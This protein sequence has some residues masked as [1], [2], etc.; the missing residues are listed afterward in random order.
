MR[1]TFR[2]GVAVLGLSLFISCNPGD[3]QETAQADGTGME[4]IAKDSTEA[5]AAASLVNPVPSFFS[6]TLPCKDCPGIVHALSLETDSTCILTEQY[7]GRKEAPQLRFGRVQR[8]DS[9][10][11]LYFPGGKTT[12]FRVSGTGMHMVDERGM[13]PQP[14]GDYTLR[15]DPAGFIDLGQPYLV[16]GAYFFRSEGA[17]FTPAG[18]ATAYPV[19]PGKGSFDAEK[20]YLNRSR[21]DTGTLC[22]RAIVRIMKAK[23]LAGKELTMAHIDKVVGRKGTCK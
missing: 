2:F 20:I 19:N 11:T 16:D 22:L 18:H 23:D 5:F 9:T 1:Y 8:T 13:S 12:R 7:L 17:T 6:D 15:P 4:T 10:L 3:R 21:K 14:E